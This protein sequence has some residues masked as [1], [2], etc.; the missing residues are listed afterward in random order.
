MWG[1]IAQ[2]LKDNAVGELRTG[3]AK[4]SDVVAPKVNSEEYEEDEGEYEDEQYEDEV[5]HSKPGFR[6]ILSRIVAPEVEEEE[7]EEEEEDAFLEAQP[8]STGSAPIEFTT[9]QEQAPCYELGSSS[10]DGDLSDTKKI[11]VSS[12]MSFSA[13][14]AAEKKLTGQ[15]EQVSQRK[16]V[17]P[18]Q[19]KSIRTL[20]SMSTQSLESPKHSTRLMSNPPL[21]LNLQNQAE[22]SPTTLESEKD[23]LKKKDTAYKQP[24]I[25][26]SSLVHRRLDRP[27]IVKGDM[28]NQM[29]MDRPDSSLPAQD[30]QGLP[31][32]QSQENKTKSEDTLMKASLLAKTNGTNRP[33]QHHSQAPDNHVE[34]EDYHKSDPSVPGHLVH[35]NITATDKKKLESDRGQAHIEASIMEE[36]EQQI[37]E[38][39]RLEQDLRKQLDAAN[40]QYQDRFDRDRS[41]IQEKD[42]KL[43]ALEQKCHELGLE[44]SQRDA[45]TTDSHQKSVQK[46]SELKEKDRKILELERKCQ[47]LELQLARRE[48]HILEMQKENTERINEE[49]KW[50]ETQMLKFKQE[51]A[52]IVEANSEALG[53]EYRQEIERL[54]SELVT[55]MQ[56]FQDQLGIERMEATQKQR[57]LEQ[58]LEEMTS[59]VAHLEA[60]Q[61]KSMAKQEATAKQE[62]HKYERAARVA[63]QNLS[64]TKALLHDRNEEVKSLKATI[65]ELKSTIKTSQGEHA[66]YEEELEHLREENETLHHNWQVT[67]DENEELKK[68]ID[69][70]ASKDSIIM[71]LE[72]EIELLKESMD[73]EHAFIQSK[74]ENAESNVS[75]LEAERNAALATVRDLEQQ[76]KAALVDVDIAKA[77]TERAMLANS[78]LNR[79]LESFQSE[80]EAEIALL[81]QHYRSSEEAT[82]AAHAVALQATIQVNESKMRD[83]EYAAEA[84]V[85]K[86]QQEIQII[87]VELEDVKKERLQTR[88]SLDEA[89][90]RLQASQEDVVDRSLMKNVLLD[91][92]GRSGK[93]KEQVLEVMA[94]L[95]HFTEEEKEH[96]HLYGAS[97]RLSKVV[98]SVATFPPASKDVQS[99]EG[100]NVR[101]KFIS[102][103]LAETEDDA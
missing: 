29:V 91:W 50:R 31:L 36:K 84:E 25:Q 101:D 47:D 98:E 89:I 82:A 96:V 28:T 59:R 12:S 32:E 45:A 71:S 7:E 42:K 20:S 33:R 34:L 97:R 54:E 72:K 26:D 66:E 37:R 103:L 76:L 6:A 14:A 13:S 55:Q 35:R 38:L 69:H 44:L 8:S 46:Q 60:D 53:A 87:K 18:K 77:D 21:D 90:S 94:S 10:V 51:Q 40:S 67:E 93:S 30:D 61:E 95:L 3:L 80:R 27:I 100:D 24:D 62:L 102:F 23:D 9:S 74:A 65:K 4:L 88:R 48:E 1:K 52:D 63:E 68:Q 58:L 43:Q 81:E 15:K 56:S 17:I 49:E 22:S 99:L 73:R 41:I 92:F 86:A 19:E 11:V 78:N 16:L 85:K 57:K 83:V 75:T 64:E 39:V 70:L 2:G 5:V 79:A